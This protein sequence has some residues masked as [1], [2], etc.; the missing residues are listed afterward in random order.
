MKIIT[1]PEELD[2][3]NEYDYD[4]NVYHQGEPFSGVFKQENE[5]TEYKNGDANHIIRYY[6]NGQK[7]SE[8]YLE[9]G[10]QM[11]TLTWYQ[12]G[13]VKSE[14][15]YDYTF[16][17]EPGTVLKTGF[18]LFPNGQFETKAE[19]G[20]SRSFSS[21]GELILETKYTPQ[22]K[23]HKEYYLNGV[24]KYLHLPSINKS[25]HYTDNYL[26]VIDEDGTY[27]RSSIYIDE[28]RVRTRLE[29][30]FFSEGRAFGFSIHADR[31]RI[32]RLTTWLVKTIQQEKPSLYVELNLKLCFCQEE[33]QAQFA[34]DRLVKK[35]NV[36]EIKDLKVPKMAN[37]N[38]EDFSHLRN[39]LLT[40][41][42]K[43]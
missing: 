11:K 21:S 40:E 2:F 41:V 35:L 39:K 15:K 9:Q 23:Y 4:L 7:E 42:L 20:I 36:E 38:E 12:D 5:E 19:K 22:E 13:A 25:F 24:L 18:S 14:F 16:Y 33:V 26:L 10:A 29:Q 34:F 31:I 37:V 8:E 28:I 30:L 3:R 32:S 27:G 43:K 6:D 1:D 17:N